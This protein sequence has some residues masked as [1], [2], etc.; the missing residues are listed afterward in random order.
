M[1]EHLRR[2]PGGEGVLFVGKAQEKARVV[3]SER[4]EHEP[5]GSHYVQLVH[6]TAMVNHYYFYLVDD[7]FGPV[8]VKFGSYFPYTARLCVNGHEYVKRQLAKR[9]VAFEA[10]DNG[11]LSCADPALA[12]RLAGE[13][14]A[15][16]ID[17]LLRK[18]LKRLPHPFTRDD[19]AAGIRY[20]V[21]V[22]QAEFALTQVLD[23]PVQG[24]VFFEET[25]RENLDLGRP[26]RVQLIFDRRVTRQ[27]PSRYRT[28]VVTDGVVPSLLVDY[29]HSHIKQYY[30]GGRALRTETVVNDTYDFGVGRR[31]NN[32]DD[33]KAIGFAANRRLLGVQRI[34]HHC[35]LGLE[36]FEDLHRPAV[37]DDRRASAM[38]F[39]DPRVQALL[40][41]LLV[42]R[43]LP[44]GFANREFP[45]ARRAA[46]RTAGGRLRAGP[47]HLRPGQAA[48]AR[49]DR[50][51]PAHAPLPGHRARAPR[52]PVLLPHAPPR[53]RPGARRRR[54]R[55]GAPGARPP[56]PALRPQ[57]RTPVG[58]P[59][60]GRLRNFV[61]LSRWRLLKNASCPAC[62][63]SLSRL[64]LDRRA[65]ADSR[66][67][68]G[69]FDA[70]M[71]W[72]VGP[73]PVL[74]FLASWTGRFVSG[75]A[76]SPRACR[77][78]SRLGDRSARR[79]GHARPFPRAD[80]AS[81]PSGQD[82][83]A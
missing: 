21:S 38:R 14:D 26:D 43:L 56:R 24:R 44:E 32:F 61:Q 73:D 50:E 5:S 1:R 59:K 11:I 83:I 55:P 80:R 62:P 36:T 18:W 49:T 8:F 77:S 4:R 19:R 22:L 64:P 76:S 13:L 23:R 69:V 74:P 20:E 10:L 70:R 72:W 48:H 75:V 25:I 78:G 33:L 58:G 7:D 66:R 51:D 60:T 29:K 81:T 30:K 9:G 41:I 12:Q 3:R 46:A 63:A 40:A 35:Q 27:T 67:V 79:L 17:D 16:R 47:R 71:P 54:R 2:W 65:S 82:R 57:H 68:D 31:L 52:R 45:R 15:T 53:P 39:G 34:S 6:A 37:V 42:F 28:R